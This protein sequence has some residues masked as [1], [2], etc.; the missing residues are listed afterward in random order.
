MEIGL[1]TTLFLISAIVWMREELTGRLRITPWMLCLL[2]LAR[3]ESMI[4]VF[5]IVLL[6]LFFKRR[7][8][9][10]FG[11][12]L[13]VFMPIVVI[14]GIIGLNYS[15][16]GSISPNTAHAKSPMF[17][18]YFS[19]LF[20]L[21]HVVNYFA[22]TIKGLLL[23]TFTEPLLSTQN[24]IDQFGFIPPLSLFFYLI[25]GIPPAIR[26]I[27]ERRLGPHLFLNLWFL[28][29][30]FSTGLL[31]GSGTHHF[32]YFLPFLCVFVIY[33]FPG[34][35]VAARA[36]GSTLKEANSAIFEYSIAGLFLFVQLLTTF[37]FMLL[38]GQSAHTFREYKDVASWIQKNLGPGSRIA[39]LDIGMIGFYGGRYIYDLL[40]LATNEM[41][42][43]TFYF[44]DYMGSKYEKMKGLPPKNR[45]EYFLLHKIR[46]DER[47]DEGHLQPFRQQLIYQASPVS[48][49][50]PAIGR[51]LGIYKFDWNENANSSNTYESAARSNK[52]LDS[53]N[54]ADL[55]SERAHDY[56]F[57]PGQPQFFPSNRAVQ[58]RYPNG[59]VIMDGALG[60]DGAERFRFHAP[61]KSNVILVL[62]T[63]YIE[64]PPQVF[65]NGAAAGYLQATTDGKSWKEVELRIP[66]ALVGAGENWLEI[67]GRYMSAYYWIYQDAQN[68]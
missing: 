51:N 21:Q 52:L 49:Q 31:S 35:R 44:S 14:A 67:R 9:N 39:A 23:G 33:L 18:P 32:R 28:T 54:I 63:L 57:I 48:G 38:F 59:T 1:V 12:F 13:V 26:E 17:T 45:P 2:A 47:G 43:S 56:S 53:I 11:E 40:G 16:T 65:C 20:L 34:I 36:L 22:F 5:V 41:T 3:P 55:D 4:F 30:F 46:F 25:G 8:Q 50:F 60:I 68:L 24:R 29:G 27:R 19:F 37:N 62:R 61:D 15:L 42:S 66:A 7:T 10:P 64:R 6:L 58:A